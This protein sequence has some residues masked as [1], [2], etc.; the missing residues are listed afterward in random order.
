MSMPK[1]C[2]LEMDR[3]SVDDPS[4]P[5]AVLPVPYERSTSFGK[6]T[7]AAPAAILDASVQIEMF[8]EEFLEPLRLRVQT[9]A[10]VDCS[11]GT[12]REALEA[13]R[14]A[15]QAAFAGKKR[16]LLGL[17]GEHT[18]TAPLVEA[19]RAAHGA[20]SVLHLDAHLDLRDSYR[21]T[22][23]SHACV[24]K[25]VMEKGVPVTHVGI[26]SLCD[27]EYTLVLANGLKVFWGRSISCACDDSWMDEVV[28]R[29]GPSVY[30][31][32]DADCLDP[33]VMPGTGTPEPG[34]LSWRQLTALL[35]KVCFSRNVVSADIVEVAP[36]PGCVVSEYTAARLAAKLM[37]YHSAA[38]RAGH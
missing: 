34:G 15:A 35:R 17:G 38:E 18:V 28:G 9:L 24:M 21:G 29:L 14:A 6:G 19:C 12:E 30:V 22:A 16:F 26:R 31:T 10:E 27:E 2:F 8:D 36:I 25:R 4:A 33:S 11:M 32:I 5:Y 3:D 1:Q 7:V 20:V 37:A 23:F 13:I